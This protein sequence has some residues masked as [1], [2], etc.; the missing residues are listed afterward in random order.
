MANFSTLETSQRSGRTL[1]FGLILLSYACHILGCPISNPSILV[2]QG[3]ITPRF[4]PPR[5]GGKI[6]ALFL[7][8]EEN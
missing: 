2:R 7:N 8:R 4:P 1:G 6:L 5:G 3:Y